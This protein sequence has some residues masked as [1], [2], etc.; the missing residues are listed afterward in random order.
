MATAAATRPRSRDVAPPPPTRASRPRVNG[1]FYL[2]L[3]P[4][5]V[6]FTLCITL[7]AIMGITFS[8]TASVGFGEFEFIGF[9]N[10]VA[11][12]SDPAIRSSYLFT[13]GFALVAVLLVMLVRFLARLA[14]VVRVVL[15]ESSRGTGEPP[16][17][18]A[19]S[20]AACPRCGV[21]VPRASLVP[22]PDGLRCRACAGG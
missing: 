16:A 9:T 4:T 15:R 13:I 6:L 1:T 2:F 21:F 3:L 5:I 18:R 20:L 7:P 10:Y 17:A 8:F 19:V 11:L 14:A 12:F 22:S